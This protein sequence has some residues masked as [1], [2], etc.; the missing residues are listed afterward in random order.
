M[1]THCL[2]FPTHRL[3]GRAADTDCLSK[4]KSVFVFVGSFWPEHL[5]SQDRSSGQQSAGRHG[6][7][8]NISNIVAAPKGRE[9][10]SASNFLPELWFV[11]VSCPCVCQEPSLW[12]AT[13]GVSFHVDFNQSR[14]TNES[15]PDP[16]H[17]PE[18]QPL[19]WRHTDVIVTCR[20]RVAECVRCPHF[21][22]TLSLSL[23]YLQREC[24]TGGKT[25][26]TGTTH[27]SISVPVSNRLF[28]ASLLYRSQITDLLLFVATAGLVRIVLET[29][30]RASGQAMWSGE[31]EGRMERGPD[32]ERV[33]AWPAASLTFHG[34]REQCNASGGPTCH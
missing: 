6:W 22:V 11:F 18:M 2:F 7:G 10:Q 20:F 5:L 28:A 9:K 21:L 32:T 3:P 13:R 33:T 1:S 8:G 26:L 25:R 19:Y 14:L 31:R 23:R 27:P 16:A 15:Q 17:Q 34:L 4:C 12:S 29:V 30:C 24:L